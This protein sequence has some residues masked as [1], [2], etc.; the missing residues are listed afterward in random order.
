MVR[1]AKHI[2]ID[3]D[4]RSALREKVAAN[5]LTTPLF[6]TVRFTRNFEAAIGL[7]TQQQRSGAAGAHIDVP[8]IGPVEPQPA[9]GPDAGPAGLALQAAYPACPLCDGAS[10]SLGFANCSGHRLWHA[11]L[12]A[13]VE[14]MRCPSCGHV[15]N[16]HYWTRAAGLDEVLRHAGIDQAKRTLQA[17]TK[18]GARPGR[19]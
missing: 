6:D 9:Q 13:T 4:Y 14:W 19:R 18:P 3:A 15:H 7:M 1:I 17:D 16:R 8:D 5:R 12:P 2:G 10:V 11:P